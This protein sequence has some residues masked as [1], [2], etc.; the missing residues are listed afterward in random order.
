[1]YIHISSEPSASDSQS[2]Q[3]IKVSLDIELSDFPTPLRTTLLENYKTLL[4]RN[5]RMFHEEYVRVRG[6]KKSTH[7]DSVN[8]FLNLQKQL[9][10][11]SRI[12]QLERDKLHI[13]SV[14]TNSSSA[15]SDMKKL[16]DKF[17]LPYSQNNVDD[18]N[19]SVDTHTSSSSE[20]QTARA[21]EPFTPR[22]GIDYVAL[23]KIAALVP[24]NSE[25]L[26][27]HAVK[28]I[29]GTAKGLSDYAVL[30]SK[31][32]AHILSYNG[33]EY[34]QRKGCHYL[35]RVVNA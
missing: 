31:N 10:F 33:I 21:S 5:I 22:D 18:T 6:F 25:I 3:T 13:Q 26:L 2:L 4:E 1:M 32:R 8:S 15:I 23:D 14:A 12:A 17:V 28:E 30:F 19:K 29:N 9:D 34:F 7:D 27:K 20:N 35:R 11:V 24:S 16:I